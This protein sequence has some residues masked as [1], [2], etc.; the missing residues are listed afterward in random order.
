MDYDFIE[1]GTSNF[2]TEIQKQKSNVSEAP[3][4]RGISIEPV[5][6]YLDCLPNV[7]GVKKLNIAI[8]NYNGMV[9]VYYIEPSVLC[10]LDNMSKFVRSY[11]RGC[12]S[13]GKPHPMAIKRLI[14]Y[15]Y[16]PDLISEDNVR[17]M[18]LSDICVE[19]NIRSIHYLKIDTEGHDF[20]I[21][22]DFLD[23]IEEN[24]R[25]SLLPQRLQYESNSLT[26]KAD[27]EYI[28][29]RLKKYYKV[30]SAN[31]MDTTMERKQ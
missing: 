1:I 17:V 4:V 3:L 27:K 12:N 9:K 26:P 6:K 11:L 29:S 25:H 7:A 20:I 18:R 19:E 22:N 31:S 24:N 16:S 30:V 5:K 14:K 8:S 28:L 23:W 2:R 15:G 21:L 10:K 13:I